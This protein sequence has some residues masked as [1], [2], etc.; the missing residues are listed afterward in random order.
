MWICLGSDLAQD[1]VY[2][3][4]EPKMTTQLCGEFVRYISKR[5]ILYRIPQLQSAKDVILRIGMKLCKPEQ[6]VGMNEY[7]CW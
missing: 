4:A 1:D 6:I 5:M 7:K 3:P 2:L